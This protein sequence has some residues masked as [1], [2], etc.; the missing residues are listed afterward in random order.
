[1]GRSQPEI[2]ADIRL[3]SSLH[4]A[5]STI[6]VPGFDCDSTGAS[7][8]KRVHFL[9]AKYEASEHSFSRVMRGDPGNHF[10]VFSPKP[11]SA[12]NSQQGLTSF[13]HVSCLLASLE[14]P[15]TLKA[16]GSIGPKSAL[17][18]E[19]FLQLRGGAISWAFCP[20]CG[21]KAWALE[22]RPGAGEPPGP[23]P[24]ERGGSSASAP[25]TASAKGSRRE[26]EVSLSASFV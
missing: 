19:R 20:T 5:G 26:E 25:A 23:E 6:F 22:A 18:R 12:V 15:P 2:S 8:T 13:N 24:G 17:G 11:G 7:Q 10:E 4:G 21:R 16:L 14:M 9:S 1:M 3:L